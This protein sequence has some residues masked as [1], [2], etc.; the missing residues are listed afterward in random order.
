M[1]TLTPAALPRPTPHAAAR[2]EGPG[3]WPRDPKVSREGRGHTMQ[4]PHRPLP[5][6]D[7]CPGQHGDAATW[8]EQ[9]LFRSGRKGAPVRG[10]AGTVHIGI[11]SPPSLEGSAPTTPALCKKPDNLDFTP[12]EVPCYPISQRWKLR[13]REARVT[14]TITRRGVAKL[15]GPCAP[16]DGLLA[17][18]CDPGP[19]SGASPGLREA[20]Q[21]AERRPSSTRQPPVPLPWREELSISRD[22]AQDRC[23]RPDRG[24]E[25]KED[26]QVLPHSE[27]GTGEWGRKP[28]APQ[29]GTD[30]QLCPLGG[31]GRPPQERAPLRLGNCAPPEHQ[32]QC[33]NPGTFLVVAFVTRCPG[34]G[35]DGEAELQGCR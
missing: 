12:R 28:Q 13:L 6:P 5:G 22:W 29:E 35:G 21:R 4:V 8:C 3:L 23:V 11:C 27:A 17:G 16:R 24:P 20:T 7:L 31:R 15:P 33:S 1:P 26:W 2:S 25:E 30:P 34:P 19:T 9:I 10:R 18:A 32:E 14:C